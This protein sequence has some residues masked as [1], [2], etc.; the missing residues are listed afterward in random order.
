[1]TQGSLTT[2]MDDSKRHRVSEHMKGKEHNDFGRK[3]LLQSDSNSNAWETT[4]PNEH[5]S[6]NAGQ[7]P[8]VCHTYF[9]VP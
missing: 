3:A 6:L 1:M 7:F 8:V 5:S 2:P 9:G 4:C